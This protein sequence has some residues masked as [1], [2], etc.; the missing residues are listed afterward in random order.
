[1][2]N[3]TLN[4]PLSSSPIMLSL[5]RVKLI[6]MFL[7]LTGKESSSSILLQLL[8]LTAAIRSN[9]LMMLCCLISLI[10]ILLLLIISSFNINCSPS[11]KNPW[12]HGCIYFDCFIRLQS[13]ECSNIDYVIIVTYNSGRYAKICR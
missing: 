11:F 9:P 12:Y 5:E 1:M 2:K 6:S 10:V 8:T 3:A 4:V 13:I 7:L